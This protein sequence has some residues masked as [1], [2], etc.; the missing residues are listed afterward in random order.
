MTFDLPWGLHQTQMDRKWCEVLQVLTASEAP[1]LWKF[2]RRPV[3]GAA[4]FL[5]GQSFMQTLHSWHHFEATCRL[6]LLF[7]GLLSS[8]SPTEQEARAHSQQLGAELRRVCCC[9][10][11]KWARNFL[12]TFSFSFQPV[13]CHTQAS[14][15]K[16]HLY[17]LSS[18]DETMPSLPCGPC[19]SCI[20]FL[21]LL[22]L[23]K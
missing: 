7:C 12:L 23:Y 10:R 15:T 11:I 16:P 22:Q 4:L 20:P 13:W 19:A 14:Y 17:L 5:R 9:S 6:W 21:S 8:V 3:W 1:V 2:A 18:E